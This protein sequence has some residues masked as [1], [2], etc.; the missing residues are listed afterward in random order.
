MPSTKVKKSR[1]SFFPL[2]LVFFLFR[3][4]EFVSEEEFQDFLI[5]FLSSKGHNSYKEYLLA[6][7][8]RVDILK[9]FMSITQD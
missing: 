1:N 4:M 6:S 9:Y 2:M 8:E 5:D 3:T 7:W